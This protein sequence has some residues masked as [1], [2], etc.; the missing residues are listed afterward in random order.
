MELDFAPGSLEGG[1]PW[2]RTPGNWTGQ[3]TL[4]GRGPD[5]RSR[6]LGSDAAGEVLVVSLQDG[7]LDAG[8][9]TAAI[10]Q[11]TNCIGTVGQGLA[12]GIANR[13]PY[14]CPYQGRGYMPNSKYARR[15]DRPAPGTIEVRHPAGGQV[16]PT[17]I[18]VHAQWAPGG[19]RRAPPVVP[20]AGTRDSSQ[21]RIAWFA[22]G[23]RLIAALRPPPPSV[24]FPLGIGC[25]R[26]G[27]VW[28][29]YD[30]MIRQW[31]RENPDIKVKLIEWTGDPHSGNG[32]EDSRSYSE[33][34][35]IA[36]GWA[37]WHL[38]PATGR[39]SRPRDAGWHGG[40]NEPSPGGP[41]W[42]SWHH[43]TGEDP[44]NA[45]HPAPPQVP[46]QVEGPGWDDYGPWHGSDPGT[47]ISG[48]PSRAG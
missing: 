35:G 5:S 23:L 17:V 1:E 43:R 4:A 33:R 46:A 7:I 20:P 40:P 26:A 47:G 38:P 15:E 27:G 18:N 3:G 16:G 41:H 13:Y 9:G 19:N 10:V 25:C 6:N 42:R 37:D 2:P 31:A 39:H 22:Q 45:G 44:D 34:H 48:S 32:G 8:V 28:K 14:G 29:R 12:A 30:F 36:P 24:A 21:D 11:Q